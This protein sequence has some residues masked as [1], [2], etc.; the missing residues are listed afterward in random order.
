MSADLIKVFER[1]GWAT[2]VHWPRRAVMNR[3][4]ELV[5]TGRSGRSGQSRTKGL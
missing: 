2:E 5:A 1:M 4:R 3:R